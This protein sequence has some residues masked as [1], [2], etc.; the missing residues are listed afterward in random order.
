MKPHI[1][2]VTN[3]ITGQMYI[4]QHNGTK[5]YYYAGGV[6]I[7]R[8]LKKYGKNAFKREIIVEGDFTPDQLDVL[9]IRYI[10]E[11][12]TYFHDYP[13][14]GYNLTIG[15]TRCGGGK[16]STE[17]KLKM[18]NNS[19]KRK[20][21]V[22]FDLNGNYIQTHFNIKDAAE[23]TNTA[24]TSIVKCCT[25]LF[26]HANNFRWMHESNYLK[27]VVLPSIKSCKRKIGQYTNDGLIQIFESATDA[28][29]LL[30]ISRASIGN[31]LVGNSKSAGGFVWKYV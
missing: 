16:H 18:K 1:Y 19:A 13:D 7:N 30:N 8:A 24:R 22:Q 14:K 6:Y 5:S 20:A 3:L 17:A 15:G 4:G 26:T 2:K 29:K 27:G 23:L 11:F 12:Q 31:V 9:E 25:G 10:A 28:A 21:V